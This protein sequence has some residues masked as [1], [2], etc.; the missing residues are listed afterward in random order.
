MYNRVQVQEVGTKGIL[1]VQLLQGTC[2]YLTYLGTARQSFLP[3]TSA[4]ARG[5]RAPTFAVLG[6]FRPSSL[7]LCANPKNP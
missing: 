2:S 4:G 7:C 6:A 3:W 5:K 1:F